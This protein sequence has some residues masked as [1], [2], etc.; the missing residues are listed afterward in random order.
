[1]TMHVIGTVEYWEAQERF[2][3]TLGPR[4]DAGEVDGDPTEA[5]AELDRSLGL[6]RRAIAR[7]GVRARLCRACAT[8]RRTDRNRPG[9]SS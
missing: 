4:I 7:S 2:L 5:A 8:I 1:M 6:V 3:L 9:S